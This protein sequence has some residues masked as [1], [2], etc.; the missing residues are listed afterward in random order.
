MQHDLKELEDEEEPVKLE[1]V[2]ET[3]VV[4]DEELDFRVKTVWEAEGGKIKEN[5]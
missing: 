2:L 5:E 1:P 3:I 4:E